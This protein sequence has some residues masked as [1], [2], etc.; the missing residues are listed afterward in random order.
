[1]AKTDLIFSLLGRHFKKISSFEKIL[2][3]V[4]LMEHICIELNFFLSGCHVINEE[5]M[6]R[7]TTMRKVIMD[8][9]ATKEYSIEGIA[10]YTGIHA[11]VLSDVVAGLNSDPTLETSKKIFELHISVR[12][13]LYDVILKKFFSEYM[14]T[15]A[16]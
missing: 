1:M 15:V 6:E 12:R 4:K 10:R 8:I 3:E 13:N 9:L 7:E 16:A 5:N 11:D 14:D 2:L